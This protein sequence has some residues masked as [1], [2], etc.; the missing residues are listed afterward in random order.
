MNF[1]EYLI[2]MMSTKKRLTW[3]KVSGGFEARFTAG[4]E[5][6]YVIQIDQMN[7]NNMDG[8]DIIDILEGSFKKGPTQRKLLALLD[9]DDYYTVAF[10]N[11]SQYD[12]YGLTGSGN[13]FSILSIVAN[14]LIS[15]FKSSLSSPVKFFYFTAEEPSRRKLYGSLVNRYLK[16]K[17]PYKVF[18]ITVENE[19]SDYDKTYW[20]FYK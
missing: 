4:N 19:D 18:E 1:K 13:S 2:E 12:S 17:I 11:F 10:G 8:Y 9:K 20:L 16:N 5:N 6:V 7:I 14:G 3:K 15:F